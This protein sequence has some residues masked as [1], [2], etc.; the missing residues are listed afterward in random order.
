MTDGKP[1]GFIRRVEYYDTLESTNRTAKELAEQGAE[2]GTL[3]IAG[4]QTAG[5]GRLGRTWHHPANE[6]D[7]I[8]MSMILRPSLPGSGAS[9]ITII[10]ALAVHDAIRKRTGLETDIKWPN[11]LLSEGKKLCGILTEGVFRGGDYFAVLGIGLNVNAAEFPEELADTA[12]SV[13]QRTGRKTP[14]AELTDGIFEE[15]EGYYAMLT[16]DGDL[17]RAAAVYN[18]FCLPGHEIDASGH[19]LSE[20]T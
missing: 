20:T 2:E 4:R 19:R 9:M 7:A 5:R 10:A 18:R 12:C 6:G 3:V 14:P 13:Y 15:F 11:D 8:A 16:E 17:R 1:C